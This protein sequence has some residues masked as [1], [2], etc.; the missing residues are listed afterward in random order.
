MSK[1]LKGGFARL[2]HDHANVLA[3]IVCASLG[4]AGCGVVH[5]AAVGSYEVATAPFRLFQR[6][7]PTPTPPPPPPPPQPA[8]APAP[9]RTTAHHPIKPGPKHSPAPAARKRTSGKPSPSP[10]RK[11]SPSATSGTT[12]SGVTGSKPGQS[13]LFPTARSVPDKPGYVFSPSQPTKYVDVSGYAPG[14]KVKDPYSG[15]IFIVP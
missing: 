5:Q 11:S 3:G 10:S 2:I 1:K 12:S 6:P 4:L 13:S 7:T 9:A 14:S 8:P 15:Q